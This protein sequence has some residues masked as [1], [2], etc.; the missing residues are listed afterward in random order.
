MEPA[1]DQDVDQQEHHGECQPEIAKDFEGD[2]PL[3]VPLHGEA[4]GGQRL[5]GHE[6]LHRVALRQMQL[7]EGTV[8]FED[9]VDRAL[10]AAGDVGRDVDDRHQ[11][12]VVDALRRDGLVDVHERSEGNEFPG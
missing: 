6:P 2:V 11:V 9:G 1:D 12:L 5:P 10:L 7:V 3:A 8:Q 4:I